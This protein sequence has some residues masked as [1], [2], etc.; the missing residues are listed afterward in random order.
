MKTIALVIFSTICF[1]FLHA[2]T[3]EGQPDFILF[4]GQDT[5]FCF[6]TKLSRANGNVSIVEYIDKSKVEKTIKRPDTDNILSMRLRGWV[7][8]YVPRNPEKPDGYMSHLEV[9][10]DGKIRMYYNVNVVAVTDKKGKRELYSEGGGSS[11]IFFRLENGKLYE[12]TKNNI[13]TVLIPH[14]NKCSAYKSAF[15]EEVNKKTVRDA[16]RAYNKSCG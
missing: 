11:S 3:A 7:M 15:K 12:E 10:V 9:S 6:I 2:Q 14:L 1:D 4:K 16:V 5:V 13:E 8:D